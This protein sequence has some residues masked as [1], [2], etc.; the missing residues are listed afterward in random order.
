[1]ENRFDLY[2]LSEGH[3]ER[4]EAKLEAR[5][6][7]RRRRVP[8]FW[9]TAAA[10]VLA[11]VLWIGISRPHIQRAR[12]PEAVYTAYLEQIGELYHLLAANASDGNETIDW[13]AVLD[14]LTGETVP[15]YDQLPEEMPEKEKTAVLKEYYGG[16]LDE[17]E[18]FTEKMNRQKNTSR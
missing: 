8:M 18:Q 16:L 3:E 15:L 13:Q 7:R 2:E 1:M 14:E 12:T 6:A 17:A 9:A 11:L 4:F 10:A 5:L